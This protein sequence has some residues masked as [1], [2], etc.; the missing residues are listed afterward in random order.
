MT[1][2]V[3]VVVTLWGSIG[4]G[5]WSVGRGDA[6]LDGVSGRCSAL[7][8]IHPSNVA[9][10]FMVADFRTTLVLR[11]CAAPRTCTSAA[12]LPSAFTACEMAFYPDGPL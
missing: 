9:E 4:G 7:P 5:G 11:T 3:L 6:P 1:E 2:A 8:P 10:S 12:A